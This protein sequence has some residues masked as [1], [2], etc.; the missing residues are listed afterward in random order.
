MIQLVILDFYRS[1]TSTLGGGG[2]GGTYKTTYESCSEVAPDCSTLTTEKDRNIS[3]CCNQCPGM[4]TSCDDI[5]AMHTFLFILSV[6]AL[7]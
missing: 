1:Q 7:F 6:T 4:C 3:I 5:A 2:G